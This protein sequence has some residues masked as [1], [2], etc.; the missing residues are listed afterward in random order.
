MNKKKLFLLCGLSM[1]II[2]VI[3][4]EAFLRVR[5]GLGSPV[6]SL[7]DEE[8]DYLF[9]P[10]QKCCRFGHRVW[11]NNYSMR[12]DF[13]V[14]PG[15]R[16][17][18]RRILVCG[19][20]VINGGTLTDQDD[21]GTTIAQSHYNTND[22]QLLN[23]SAGSWGPGNIA[24][25][26]GKFGVFD[27]TDLI[28][29]VDSHD[30]W[31]DNP[32]VGKGSIVGVD[33]SFPGRKPVLALQELVVRY[34]FPRLLCKLGLAQVN[35]KVDVARWGDAADIAAQEYNLSKMQEL[36]LL[37]IARKFLLIHRSRS[38][39]ASGEITYGEAKFRE[40]AE[41][42]GVPVYLLELDADTDY[43]D[44]IH[45]NEFGQAKLAAL[46]ERIL[47]EYPDQ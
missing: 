20:S 11:Y 13:D 21:V 44:I 24:A 36:Y 27:S 2:G 31:E 6:L 25:Y 33:V 42:F 32:A 28:I 37:P 30:L 46:I 47:N 14:T 8:I 39:T 16:D 26:F 38:E 9:L 34:L 7:G 45:M 22:V 18:R 10:N 15:A 1:T 35:T 29:E 5:Y 23:V 41:S 4:F 3:G 19:D 12:I 17:C 40:Q 43:R